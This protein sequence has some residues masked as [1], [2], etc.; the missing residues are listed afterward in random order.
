MKNSTAPAQEA[1]K[2][3][4]PSCSNAAAWVYTVST[5][6]GRETTVACQDDV[7]MV[8]AH[9]GNNILSVRRTS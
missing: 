3:D 8:R 4:R 2:C 5:L 7:R 6:D 9:H 1:Q